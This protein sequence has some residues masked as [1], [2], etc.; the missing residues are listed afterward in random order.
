M[1]PILSRLDVG[2]VPPD[3]VGVSIMTLPPLGMLLLTETE[4]CD[5]DPMKLAEL[6]LVSDVIIPLSTLTPNVPLEALMLQNVA[7][8]PWN[9]IV[10]WPPMVPALDVEAMKVIPANET[11]V[12]K[13]RILFK[14]I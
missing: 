7:T 6:S 9:P 1:P 3:S 13:A 14:A 5:L 12:I 10:C 11:E 8:R 2:A 4:P